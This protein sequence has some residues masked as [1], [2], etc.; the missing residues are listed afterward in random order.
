MSLTLAN[1]NRL[2]KAAIHK[3]KIGTAICVS[4]AIPTGRLVAHQRMDGVFAEASLGSIGK[5]IA[6][7]RT[8]HASGNP[9]SPESRFAEAAGE[10]VAE[11]A[12]VINRR[13]GIPI[14]Q[15]G[16]LVGGIGVS[17]LQR[18]NKMKCVPS[19]HWANK[20]SLGTRFRAPT[21]STHSSCAGSRGIGRSLIQEHVGIVHGT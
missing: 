6:S 9:P 16:Q 2:V 11:G 13:G 19:A 1:A 18:M 3:A 8:G 7:V 14:F 4:V 10:V 17:A 21:C 15:S 5:A 12:P 20:G